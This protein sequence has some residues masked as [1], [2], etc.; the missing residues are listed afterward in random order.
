M[1][2]YFLFVRLCVFQEITTETPG[3]RDERTLEDGKMSALPQKASK[4]YISSL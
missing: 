4:L 3:T 1:L 2:I